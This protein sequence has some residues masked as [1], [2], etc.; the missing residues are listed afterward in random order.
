MGFQYGFYLVLDLN[1]CSGFYRSPVFEIDCKGKSHKSP[2]FG[3]VVDNVRFR[4]IKGQITEKHMFVLIPE[5]LHGGIDGQ[6][7]WAHAAAADHYIGIFLK[8]LIEFSFGLNV[9]ESCLKFHVKV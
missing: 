2:A 8:D 4:M 5:N 6:T 1:T 9:F 7:H 3:Q